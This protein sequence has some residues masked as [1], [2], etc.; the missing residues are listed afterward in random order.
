MRSLRRRLQGWTGLVDL[1]SAVSAQYLVDLTWR[2]LWL[3][4]TR[5]CFLGS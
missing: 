1:P 4:R 3:D 5:L 2:A